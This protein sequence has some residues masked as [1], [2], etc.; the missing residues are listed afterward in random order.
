MVTT[1]VATN[2]TTASVDKTPKAETLV[3]RFKK[4]GRD[5]R[6]NMTDDQKAIE[7]SD[8]DKVAFVACLMNPMKIQQRQTKQGPVKSYQVV[9]YKFKLNKDIVL[10][11]A[12]LQSADVID[13][14]PVRDDDKAT[15]AGT[16]VA[17]NLV[18][19]AALMSRIEFA[20]KFSGDPNAVVTLHV[21]ASE[22]DGTAP[23]YKPNLKCEGKSIKESFEYI[24]TFDTKTEKNANGD[25][26][27]RHTSPVII[28]E[29]AEK[30]GKLLEK[31][32]AARGQ[33]KAPA[34]KGESSKDI[35]AAFR[36]LYAKQA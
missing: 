27:E 13:C 15:P 6:T 23:V 29:Y 2:P 9:G 4:S 5:A 11:V 21:K 35:A 16:V 8:S 33:G 36:N 3:D 26:V 31:K 7:G 17:L 14:A 30:F 32:S 24:A 25:M 34:A 19:T 12:P 18:E 22:K 28:P 10:P 20:G 1:N